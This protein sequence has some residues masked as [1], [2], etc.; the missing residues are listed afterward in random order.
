MGRIETLRRLASYPVVSNKPESLIIRRGKFERKV[1]WWNHPTFPDTPHEFVFEP[2]AFTH[3]AIIPGTAT[4]FFYSNYGTESQISDIFV[5]DING[6]YTLYN[7]PFGV[8][9]GYNSYITRLTVTFK[10]VV[11]QR[12]ELWLWD[13]DMKPAIPDYNVLKATDT[14]NKRTV[15][16]ESTING[17]LHT[18]DQTLLNPHPIIRDPTRVADGGDFSFVSATGTGST[19]GGGGS[20]GVKI[21]DSSSRILIHGIQTLV[22]GLASSTRIGWFFYEQDPSDLS[23]TVIFNDWEGTDVANNK[24]AIT[25]YFAFDPPIALLDGFDLSYKTSVVGTVGGWRTI[26]Y[27]SN[28]A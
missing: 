28:R 12:I 20:G 4:P 25:R 15:L 13:D 14:T 23:E 7:M 1:L 9:F 21:Y 26:I 8:P 27:F 10:P 22:T 17:A 16:L 11:Y 5:V 19:S 2:G 3:F 24:E 6:Q 18:L